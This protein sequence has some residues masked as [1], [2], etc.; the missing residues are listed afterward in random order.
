MVHRL[1]AETFIPKVDGKP[2]VNHIDGNPQN[3]KVENLEWVTNA[4]NTLHAYR[5][6]LNKRKQKL[7]TVFGQTL[8][9]TQWSK[10]MGI[11]VQKLSYLLKKGWTVE[12]A[13]NEFGYRE[14]MISK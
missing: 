7:F 8:N 5:T 3:N 13:L 9:M 1:V 6:L 14:E 12:R 2:Q 4:E 10:V 11:K